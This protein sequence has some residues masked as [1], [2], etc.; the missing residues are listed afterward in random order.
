LLGWVILFG[1]RM[2]YRA[3]VPAGD[4]RTVALAKAA[5]VHGVVVAAMA[6]GAVATAQ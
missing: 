5:Q 4:G 1:P 3:F 2:E 6:A